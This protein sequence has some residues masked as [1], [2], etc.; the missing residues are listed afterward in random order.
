VRIIQ[1]LRRAQLGAAAI[2]QVTSF[3]VVNG[4]SIY[5]SQTNVIV[6]LTSGEPSWVGD[7]AY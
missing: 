2:P 7:D 6:S 5:S 1:R 3:Q 4:D